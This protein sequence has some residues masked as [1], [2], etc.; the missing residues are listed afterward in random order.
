M[1]VSL[2]FNQCDH[3]FDEYTGGTVLCTASTVNEKKQNEQF[4][5]EHLVTD[6]ASFE[7]KIRTI[8]K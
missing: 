5:I 1:W 2:H 7:I 6:D 4:Y 3:N 8:G